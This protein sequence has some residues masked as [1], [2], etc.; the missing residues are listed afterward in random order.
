MRQQDLW[1]YGSQEQM[2]AE[3]HQSQIDARRRAAKRKK[4]LRREFLGEVLC[5]LFVLTVGILTF[6]ALS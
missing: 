3:I 2:L 4:A 5:V 6:W 1:W